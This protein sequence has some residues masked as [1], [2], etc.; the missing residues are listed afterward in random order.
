[1]QTIL[2]DTIAAI[3]TASG[4]AAIAMVRLSGPDAIKIVHAVFDGKDLSAVESHTLHFG[5]IQDGEQLVDEV[6]AGV[7]RG[8]NSY[9]GEDIVEISNFLNF[10]TGYR[11][12]LQP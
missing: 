2:G 4:Q 11:V 8:P 12:D 6:V 10:V 7:F 9:T 1:M 5:L 3:S